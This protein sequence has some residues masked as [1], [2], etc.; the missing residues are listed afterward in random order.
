MTTTLTPP[1]NRFY[2]TNP[3]M[4]N[5]L[6][7]PAVRGMFGG[8]SRTFPSPSASV[9][10]PISAVAWHRTVPSPA[11]FPSLRRRESRTL[12]RLAPPKNRAP[13]DGA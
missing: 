9:D 8:N 12:R 7:S 11:H 6:S 2:E 3:S 1:K 5:V 4:E 13:A 10:L